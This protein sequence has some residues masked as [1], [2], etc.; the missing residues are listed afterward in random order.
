MASLDE[1]AT[2]VA[3]WA[4]QRADL[5]EVTLFGSRVVGSN[6]HGRPVTPKSDLD[7]AIKLTEKCHKKYS[8]LQ[9]TDRGKDKSMP[10]R[11]KIVDELERLEPIRNIKVH[12]VF[13]N[14]IPVAVLEDM[15]TRGCRLVFRRT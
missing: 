3:G 4:A 1:I 14:F 8:K 11:N 13:I 6:R 15:Q 5:A 10:Y 7:V 12:L 9:E 2:A